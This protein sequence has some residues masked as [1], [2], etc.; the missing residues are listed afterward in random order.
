MLEVNSHRIHIR[1]CI[2]GIKE[3]IGTSD[4]KFIDILQITSRQWKRIQN[5]AEDYSIQN[6]VNL[7]DAIGLNINL[8]SKGKID[9]VT[10]A[11]QFNN[12]LYILP[13]RYEV[14]QEKL[15][16]MRSVHTIFHALVL[17]NGYDYAKRIFSR[18]QVSPYAISKPNDVVSLRL[19]TDI[20]S[21]LRKEKF[22]NDHIMKIGTMANAINGSDI[23]GKKFSHCTSPKDVYRAMHEEFMVYFDKN[24]KYKL[25]KLSK[26]KCVVEIK[27]KP[28]TSEIFK[29][30]IVGS[31]EGCLCR[32][33]I[34]ASI[35]ALRE[36]KLAKIKETECMY[37]N[38]KR[39]VYHLSW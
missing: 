20:L 3:A 6:I 15:S 5:G 29:R 7:C 9:Y 30:K 10:I 33:G 23:L 11:E 26:Y 8:I 22:S 36:A 32:Q 27:T 16:K 28:K 39:C 13:A 18:F 35:L 31:R 2:Q 17:M 24:W 25:L 19:I 12:N 4:T 38:S 34:Y 14:A 21:E 37:V 1:K